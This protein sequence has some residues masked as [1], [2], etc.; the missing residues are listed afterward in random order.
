MTNIILLALVG[1]LTALTSCNGQ[2]QKLSGGTSK[3]IVAINMVAVNINI[4][5]TVSH[6]GK[7]IDWIFQDKNDIYWLASNGE[8]VYRC[9]GKTIIH[10]TDKD[11][12][13]SNFVWKILEDMNGNLWFE[14]RDGVCRFDGKAFTNYTDTITNAPYIYGRPTFTKSGLFFNHLNG[15][16]Y[17]DGTSFTNFTIH[18]ATYRPETSTNY[19]PYGIYCT[20]VDNSGKVWFGTQEKGV[21]VYDGIT[22]SFIDGKD[23]GGPAV[24]SIFQDKNGVVWFGNNGGGFYRYDGKTLR[25]ITKEKNLGNDEFLKGRKSVDKEGSLARV[26]AINQDQEGNIWIGT[27][28]AGV[29]K[30]DGTNLTNYTSKDGLSGNAVYVISKDKKG[31][32]WFVSNGEAIFHFDGQKFSKATF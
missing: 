8:G 17:Y 27:V 28:D 7:N 16:C 22:F 30:Y 20:F 21:C 4:G 3:P 18:P 11:G 31:K 24:R 9:D 25:N 2:N 5:D 6:I 13:C 12:L 10:I 32:L 26:F 14:T 19:R 23:L 29:W 1:I 15:I